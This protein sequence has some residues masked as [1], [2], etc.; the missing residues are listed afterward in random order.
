MSP[1]LTTFGAASNRGFTSGTSI[2]R[3]ALF[4]SRQGYT[5]NASGV[6]WGF[7]DLGESG[8]DRMILMDVKK[9]GTTAVCNTV[10]TPFGNA[11]NVS[12][13]AHTS[14]QTDTG[15]WYITTD[16]TTTSGNIGVSFNSTFSDTA[17]LVYVIYGYSGTPT[18]V[19]GS[20]GNGGSQSFTNSCDAGKFNFVGGGWRGSGN[21]T[22]TFNANGSTVY[23]GLRSQ[24]TDY[25]VN[26][27]TTY[28]S[29]M[30][31]PDGSEVG[32]E[33]TS[34]RGF[35]SANTTSFSEGMTYGRASNT[36]GYE[37]ITV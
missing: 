19:T 11:T 26:E 7:S 32:S 5:P 15:W 17:I 12:G 9:G 30:V 27:S 29:F 36:F 24:R 37:V 28:A 23:N 8:V 21:H 3:E 31:G 35:S 13:T 20:H 18:R 16:S 25:F 14:N 22:L 2:R 1:L 34:G 10:S 6:T 4:K 33:S